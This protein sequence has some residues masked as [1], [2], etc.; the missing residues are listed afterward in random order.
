M[1]SFACVYSE[2]SRNLH[3]SE[4]ELL[5]V[6]SP[7]LGTNSGSEL[8]HSLLPVLAISVYDGTERVAM[9]SLS[10]INDRN[11]FFNYGGIVTRHLRL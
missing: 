9:T 11:F 7:K 2:Q 8:P 1:R 10:Q 4:I 5:K 6:G 3:N